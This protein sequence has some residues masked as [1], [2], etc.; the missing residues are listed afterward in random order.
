MPGH[1]PSLL[2]G[3]SADERAFVLGSMERR[4]F[5]AG[6]VVIAEGDMLRELLIVDAGTA[7]VSMSDQRGVEHHVGLASPGTSLGEMSLFTH[8]PAAA[9]VRAHSTLEVHVLREADFE[10]LAA[11]FPILYRNLGAILSQR[12]VLTNRRAIE[13]APGRI[14]LVRDWGAPPD[15]VWAFAC[16]VAWHVG[17]R[18][19]LVREGTFAE[20]FA[21]IEPAA[22][23][24]EPGHAHVM[25]QDEFTRRQTRALT[26]GSEELFLSNEHILVHL[27]GEAEQALPASRTIHL[28]PAGATPP[29]GEGELVLRAWSDRERSRGSVIDVPSSRRPTGR[30]SSTRRSPPGRRRAACSAGSRA[31]SRGSRSGSR[32]APGASAATRTSASSTCSPAPAC[33]STTS[34]ARASARSSAASTRPGGTRPRAATCST[35]SATR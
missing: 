18:T 5:E 35:R 6:A 14:T 17:G 33:R 13:Q 21:A 22:Q 15:L 19:L 16:S 11:R 20:S 32:S 34:R 25:I 8:Q 31:R 1:A 30:P 2:D 24:R 3:L 23:R 27:P 28:A 29:A 26:G 4:R 7:D 12:L 10:S 9:T